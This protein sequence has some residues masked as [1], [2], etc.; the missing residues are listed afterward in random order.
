[1][2]APAAKAP[3]PS[4]SGSKAR[5]PPAGSTGGT[6]IGAGGPLW[7]PAGGVSDTGR[8]QLAGACAAAATAAAPHR[9]AA[10]APPVIAV[11]AAQGL[12]VE[13]GATL[14]AATAPVELT[15]SD[16]ATRMPANRFARLEPMSILLAR[17]LVRPRRLMTTL[18][19]D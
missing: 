11:N 8:T 16:P 9:A 6:G 10:G 7:A 5:P 3:S 12:A 17:R 14:D 18:C 1:M 13:I 2:S 4:S 19:P 15:K